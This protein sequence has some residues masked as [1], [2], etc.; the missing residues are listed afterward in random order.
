MSENRVER[1]LEYRRHVLEEC[2]AGPAEVEEMLPYTENPF[3]DVDPGKPDY[4][5]EDE[6][7]I[8]AWLEYEADAQEMGS[9][10]ALQRRF[11]QLRFPIREG[12]S[13]E[14]AY[15]RATRKGEMSAADGFAP[16]LEL[17]RPDT[18]ALQ[19]TPTI[20]GRLPVIVAEEREDFVALVRAFTGRN[21]PID[22]PNSM[23]ASIV[24]GLNNW[25][26][27]ARYRAEW[28]KTATPGPFG[29]PNWGEE[30]KKLAARKELYQDRFV[31]LSRGPY[32]AVSA[33][34][35]GFDDDEWR[36]LS[37]QIRREH[38]FT[39]YFTLRVYGA[40]RNNLL[41]ELVADF[42]GLVRAM[43]KY[44]SNLALMFFG[45]EDY[46]MFRP[47]GRLSGYRGTPPLSDAAFTVLQCLAWRCARNMEVFSNEHRDMLDD[48]EGVGQV[49]AAF[50]GLTIEELASDEMLDRARARFADATA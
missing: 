11:P 42:V 44:S 12:M 8:D 15:R 10:A 27:I 24:T 16:G 37:L 7:L 41:D 45:L 46:P 9:F 6:P 21:E 43:G 29:G 34:M 31:L 26:R 32:S 39:H 20:A 3:R 25:D 19:V 5:L 17:K 23:G 30:F 35:A 13:E 18:V 14:D 47:G 48:L 50:I 22:V 36:D 28:E 49:V 40:M 1:D 33:R 38:E 2:G 4:P